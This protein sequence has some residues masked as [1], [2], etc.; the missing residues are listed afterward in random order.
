M[1][2]EITMEDNATFP[3]DSSAGKLVLDFRLKSSWSSSRAHTCAF[4]FLPPNTSRPHPTVKFLDNE[5]FPFLI[6]IFTFTAASSSF[7]SWPFD[8]SPIHVTIGTPHIVERSARNC[9]LPPSSTA[10]QPTKRTITNEEGQRIL[11]LIRFRATL[12]NLSRAVGVGTLVKL[13]EEKG[14][15][16]WFLYFSIFCCGGTGGLL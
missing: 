11:I 14:A 15:S 13:S 2:E 12:A 8:K 9:P 5:I 6:P 7:S 1:E 16:K 4:S 3:S 10:T